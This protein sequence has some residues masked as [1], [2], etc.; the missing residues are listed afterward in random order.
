MEFGDFDDNLQMNVISR[1]KA[2]TDDLGYFSTKSIYYKLN[3]SSPNYMPFAAANFI[4]SGV[5]L[6]LLRLAIHELRESIWWN[7]EGNYFVEDTTKIGSCST[8]YQVLKIVWKFDILY[9]I[10]VCF[11]YDGKLSAYTF[12]PYTDFASNIWIESANH[13]QE[14]GHTFVIFKLKTPANGKYDTFCVI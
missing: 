11:E 3:P 5:N 10:F 6:T 14:N 13:E 4:I 9:A 8:A 1:L 7:L 2:K 12:N